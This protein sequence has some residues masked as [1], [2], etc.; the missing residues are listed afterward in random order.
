MAN[1]WRLRSQGGRLRSPGM[2]QGALSSGVPVTENERA[3]IERLVLDSPDQFILAQLR[4]RFTKPSLNRQT[5]G[6]WRLDDYKGPH[7]T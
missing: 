2:R 3:L 6:G 7:G 1:V 5:S 4:V